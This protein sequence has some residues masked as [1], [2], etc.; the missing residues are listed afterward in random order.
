MTI[1]PFLSYTCNQRSFPPEL[2]FKFSNSKRMR[3]FLFLLFIAFPFLISAQNVTVKITLN[4]IE[5]GVHS[6]MNVTL[7]DMNTGAKFSGK[8][9][10]DGKV[11]IQVPPNAAYEVKIPNYTE[12]K[13]INIPNA[14]NA[15]MSSTLTYSRNMLAEEAAF[16]MTAAEKKEV[17]D[18]AKALPDTTWF[19]SGDPFNGASDSYYADI[20]LDLKDLR[21][22]PLAGETVTLIGR[23]RHK[24]FKGVTNSSGMIMLKLPKGDDYDLS[25]QYHKNFEY[26]E[27]KY[28]KGTSEIKWEFEYMGTKE[29][30]RKR[31]EAEDKQKAEIAAQLKAIAQAKTDSINAIAYAKAQRAANFNIPYSENNVAAVFERNNYANP[32]VICDATASMTMIVDE[33]QLWFGK[34]AKEKPK[35]QFVFFNGGDMKGAKEK[36]NGETG[37]FYYTQ[38]L[39]LDKLMVFVDMVLAKTSY[40]DGQGYYVSALIKGVQMAKEPYSDIVLIVDNHAT[41]RDMD[42]LPQFT[43]KPVH[44]VVF[45]SIKG[46]C[47]HSMC[48][49]DYLKIAYKT[50]GTL[51]IDGFDYNNIATMKN[52]DII[53]VTGARTKY[54]LMNG[55]FFPL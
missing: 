17:D 9:G 5:G 16:E 51:S 30:L 49:P 53:E 52:G 47:D 19:K 35:S 23:K 12:K 7:V 45:C 41:T 25:F 24:A 29:F 4:A 1:R 6:N 44:V 20:E 22:G 18:F 32:L 40:D 54:K 42:L 10:A 13:I 33:L 43:G 15:T 28:S 26:T 31:K 55:E 36:K 46:G 38:A 27:C 3:N 21:N 14:P 2:K 11:S 8:T 50:K 39:P 48:Q 37:G 34:N